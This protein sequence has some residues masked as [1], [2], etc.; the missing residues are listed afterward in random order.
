MEITAEDWYCQWSQHTEERVFKHWL[1]SLATHGWENW[2]TMMS[3]SA[4]HFITF[5]SQFTQKAIDKSYNSSFW[6]PCIRQT[7]AEFI[8]THSQ[9][10]SKLKKYCEKLKF[11]HK[12]TVQL[13]SF[14]WSHT[15]VSSTDLKVRTALYS[16]INSTTW[17]Y[18][19]AI[20][21]I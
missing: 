17:K 2:L 4:I 10:R 7:L 1:K 11:P 5:K 16:I 9:Q 3:E 14:E 15:R 19:C 18:C 13:L 20:A 6:T 8:C 21:F 12:S